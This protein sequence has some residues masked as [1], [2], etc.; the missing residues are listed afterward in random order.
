[1]GVVLLL[2]GARA[3]PTGGSIPARAFDNRHLLNPDLLPAADLLLAQRIERA[4]IVSGGVAADLQA[5]VDRLSA[6]GLEIS[7]VDGS[8]SARARL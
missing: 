4:R 7:F 1:M 3:G 2:D 5:Y 6:A 8:G